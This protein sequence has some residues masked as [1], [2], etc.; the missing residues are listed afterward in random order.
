MSKELLNYDLM[1][2]LKP[3]I[4]AREIALAAYGDNDL[5]EIVRHLYMHMDSTYRAQLK[6]YIDDNM[7]Q[8]RKDFYT[9]M[10][11]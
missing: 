4:I 2:E 8:G 11:Y 5:Y 3:E 1:Q 7:S 9:K 10:G 6:E